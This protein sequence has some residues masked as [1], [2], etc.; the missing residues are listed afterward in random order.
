[1]V[2][3]TND[4]LLIDKKKIEHAES[5]LRTYLLFPMMVLLSDSTLALAVSACQ[6]IDFANVPKNELLRERKG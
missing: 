2:R 1:M 6:A 4:C 3:R 5:R